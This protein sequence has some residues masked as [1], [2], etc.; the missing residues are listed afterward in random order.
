LTKWFCS[1]RLDG[2]TVDVRASCA[3]GLDF[4]SRTGQISHSVAIAN[5]SPP[6]QHLRKYCSCKC[7]LGA[8]TRRWSPHTLTYRLRRNMASIMKGLVLVWSYSMFRSDRSTFLRTRPNKSL[9]HT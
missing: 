1:D 5:G 7:C 8:M 2:Q 4:K 9:Q 3:G 6:L